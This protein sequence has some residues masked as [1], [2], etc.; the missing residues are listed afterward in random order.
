MC[1]MFRNSKFCKMQNVHML[2]FYFMGQNH[3][4]GLLRRYYSKISVP[5]SFPQASTNLKLG[6]NS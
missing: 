3:N 2:G 4:V 5:F 1:K 6:N